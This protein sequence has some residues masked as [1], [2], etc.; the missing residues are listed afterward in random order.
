VVVLFDAYGQGGSTAA[1]ASSSDPA[2]LQSA[3][4]AL[5]YALATPSKPTT[6]KGVNPF[7]KISDG[8]RVGV[9]GQSMGAITM[10][11][12]GQLDKR[13]DAIASYDSCERFNDAVGHLDPADATF[14]YYGCRSDPT[15][16]T[17]K[18][19][20]TPMLQLQADGTL[21]G[22]H[23]QPLPNDPHRKDAYYRTLRAQGIETVQINFRAASHN[24]S[25]F[26]PGPGPF[27]QTRFGQIL[28]I[29][30]TKAWFDY[31]LKGTRPGG[32]ALRSDACRRL[33][34]RT[35][36]NSADPHSI[37]TGW[38][39]ATRAAEAG[40]VLAGNVSPTINGLIVKDRLSYHYLSG[41]YLDKGRV[42]TDDMRFDGPSCGR[43]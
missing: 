17:P 41:Y 26:V 14:A 5:D 32:A 20:R 24:D 35:Y 2:Y 39:D 22:T 18:Q 19:L 10:N 30:Y 9:G 36:D 8:S 12:V 7:W 27:T 3:R 6:S 40:D 21:I 38:F 16:L 37:G 28:H 29:Y 34:A 15:P 23:P 13:V 43:R 25:A 42:R 11:Y 1:P 31:Q 33:T 4:A